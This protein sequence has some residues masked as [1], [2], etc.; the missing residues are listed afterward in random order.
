VKQS[1]EPSAENKNRQINRS[2]EYSGGS[3]GYSILE[4]SVEHNPILI[5]PGFTGGRTALSEFANALNK[6]SGRE[7]IYSDQPVFGKQPKV[8]LS[9]INHQAEAILAIIKTEGM[10]DIPFDVI[11]HSFGSMIAVKAAELAKEQGIMA[12]DTSEGSHTIFIAPGGTNDRE[13][14][15][16]LGGRWVKFL[17]KDTFYRGQLDPTGEM[18]KA[19]V[20]NFWS[21]PSKTAKE[22]LALRKKD[23]IYAHLGD[24]G[25][26]PF[27]LGFANDSIYPHKVIE[28]VLQDNAESLSGYAVPV[29]SGVIGAAN[30]KSFVKK[31]GL[32]VKE[33]KE[34]W[35]HHYRNANHA[36]LQY[37]PERTVKAILQIINR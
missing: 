11:T 7:V 30:F 22:I 4:G 12:F 31:S 8:K 2:A 34:A 21:D 17:A 28:N 19:G 13:N 16:F 5:I 18:S 26:K 3:V 20:K 29:D 6:E 1:A 27:I 14:L 33:A 32:S 23:E 37:H 24:L 9:A 36:D 25:L 15:A 35:A 10:E